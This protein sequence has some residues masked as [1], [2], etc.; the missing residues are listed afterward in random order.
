MIEKE[1]M[2]GKK[3]TFRLR[4]KIGIIQSGLELSRYLLK[5]EKFYFIE[6]QLKTMRLFLK[7]FIVVQVCFSVLTLKYQVNLIV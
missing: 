4:A 2:R 5:C 6:C 7:S 1:W 3:E